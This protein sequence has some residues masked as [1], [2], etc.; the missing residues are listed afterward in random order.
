M[1][2]RA[3]P[4]EAL[5]TQ[6]VSR[7]D[8]ELIAPV[9]ALPHELRESVCVEALLDPTFNGDDRVI[10]QTSSLHNRY[11]SSIAAVF[12]IDTRWHRAA[13]AVRLRYS[14]GATHLLKRLAE[15]VKLEPA[16][17]AKVEWLVIGGEGEWRWRVSEG[18][19]LAAARELLPQLTS[20]RHAQLTLTPTD[21]EGGREGVAGALAGV[22]SLRHLTVQAADFGSLHWH[23]AHA[24]TFLAL[25]V[26]LSSCA[27]QLRT[28]TVRHL[29]ANAS[30]AGSATF[31]LP[32]LREL[33]V[34][35]AGGPGGYRVLPALLAAAPGV[36]ILTIGLGVADQAKIGWLVPALAAVMPTTVR[37]LGLSTIVRE[38]EAFAGALDPIVRAANGRLR[39]L[40]VADPQIV[41]MDVVAINADLRLLTLW[42]WHATDQGLA[43]WAPELRP[44]LARLERL[45]SVALQRHVP[46]P[47]LVR[48]RRRSRTLT[49]R[50]AICAGCAA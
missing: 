26:A 31:T 32:S 6:A 18:A 27:A 2:V 7:L 49:G 25:G 11:L 40:F 3:A 33:H 23:R 12:L 21:F 22:T 37:A 8:N 20:L 44:A 14:V 34:D 47:L 13:A 28:L 35:D 42:R 17:A 9:Y 45:E 1:P 24:S 36:T 16:L 19:A 46:N 48:S 39:A 29:R 43:A 38:P 30:A 5:L 15:A 10:V 50:S 4:R 41:S